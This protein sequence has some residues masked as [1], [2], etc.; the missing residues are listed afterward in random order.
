MTECLEHALQ[1][2]YAEADGPQRGSPWPPSAAWP[3][4][5]WDHAPTSTWCCC[6]TARTGSW[7]TPSP[8]V[9]GIPLWDS[10][11]RLDHSVR[12]PAECADVAGRELS[13][14][15]GLLDL[16][17][18]AGDAELVRGARSALLTAWRGNARKRLPELLAAL[19]ERHESFGD[20]AYLL[21]PD[22]K[23]AR[24]GFRDMIMLRALAATWLTDRP[25]S[26]VKDPYEQLLDVR[27]ALHLSSGRTMDRLLATEVDDVASRLQYGDADDLRRAVSMA[28]RRIGHA[29]DLTSRAARQVLPVR[30]KLSFVRRERRPEYTQAPHGLIVHAGEVGLDRLTSPS[31]PL[32]DLR[33]G[34]LAAQ[35]GLVLS[36][37]TADNLGAHAPPV[38]D[39]LAGRGSGHLLRAAVRRNLDAARSGRASIWPA[40]SCAGSRRGRAS[41]HDRSTTRCT[42]TPSTGTRCSAW[43]RCSGT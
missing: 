4:A 2:L 29:V 34:A 37:V 39:A 11:V 26:G 35:R 42:G 9:S 18:L 38:P 1:D 20:A 40:A 21:E 8:R 23:E 19:E 41:A 31:T 27:D 7:S 28:A 36:P 3:G 14:G 6:T 10:S 25:H 5:S 15:V 12:T 17:V 24:G 33:A 43:P 22:L 30:R 32:L 16:R 13:A